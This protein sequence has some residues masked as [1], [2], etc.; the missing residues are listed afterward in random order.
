MPTQPRSPHPHP[1][2]A[3]LQDNLRIFHELRGPIF[4]PPH[5][6]NSFLVQEVLDKIKARREREGLGGLD[7]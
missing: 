3:L 1:H 5:L 2:P 6:R 4:P 7:G